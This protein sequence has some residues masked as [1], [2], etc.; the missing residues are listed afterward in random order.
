LEKPA[1][2]QTCATL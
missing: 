2:T 1:R